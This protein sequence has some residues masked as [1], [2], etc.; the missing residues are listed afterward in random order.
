MV[1]RPAS[2]LRRGRV[3]PFRRFRRDR[4][5]GRGCVLR[6]YESGGVERREQIPAR[7]LAAPALLRA[8]ATV[9]V[10]LGVALALIAT[11]ATRR[12][13]RLHRRALSGRGRGTAPGRACPGG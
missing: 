3:L 2:D 10:V 5:L 13:A 12:Q 1:S 9:L 7:S 11:C 4:A 8:E 6:L